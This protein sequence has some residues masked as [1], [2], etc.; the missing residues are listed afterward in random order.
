MKT[1]PQLQRAIFRRKVKKDSL[2]AV[3]NSSSI[4]LLH[5]RNNQIQ[6][7][8]G[9]SAIYTIYLKLFIQYLPLNPWGIGAILYT[10]KKEVSPK[11]HFR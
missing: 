7:E 8:I 5:R 10:T 11:N 6:I 3:L 1:N 9:N 4:L 2:T